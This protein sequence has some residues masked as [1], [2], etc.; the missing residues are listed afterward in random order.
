MTQHDWINKYAGWQCKVKM[1]EFVKIKR[2]A[3][4]PIT[5]K[6]ILDQMENGVLNMI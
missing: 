4:P 5:K 2:M 1:N 3:E 6:I